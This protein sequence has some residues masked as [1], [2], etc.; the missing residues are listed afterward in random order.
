M[1]RMYSRR[2]KEIKVVA[3]T[4]QVIFGVSLPSGSRINK[5]SCEV[6]V[7]NTALT[8]VETIAAYACEVWILPVLDPDAGASFQDIW[9][10]MVPKDTDVDTID[11]DTGGTDTT[12]FYEPGEMDLES[13]INVGRE[14]E[15]IY[16]R[17][18]LF[19]YASAPLKTQDA[20]TP[21]GLRSGFSDVFGI[22][23]SKNYA[24]SEPSVVLVAIAAP[25]FDDTTNVEESALLENEWFQV[26]YMEDTVKRAVQHL[27][28]LTE[29]GAETPWEDATALLR[30]HLDPDVF[31]ETA[32]RFTAPNWSV[33]CQGILD[34]S[35]VGTLEKLQ[36]TGGR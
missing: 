35:V 18:K 34:H 29:A 1:L 2:M 33:V 12:P 23:I 11:L 19:S 15:R 7:W 26:K 22:N 10:A 21:F 9:D 14:P 20:V 17:K 24:I 31:E 36:M 13:M 6:H 28:G 3:G 4:D 30:K 16:H 32:G 27:F 25:S 5:L 8:A